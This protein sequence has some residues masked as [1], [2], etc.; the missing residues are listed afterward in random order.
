MNRSNAELAATDEPIRHG[1]IVGRHS[2]APALRFGRACGRARVLCAHVCGR[3]H[4]R[5][6][7]P[8]SLC[9]RRR[10]TVPG[11]RSVVALDQPVCPRNRDLVAEPVYT[12]LRRRP[13]PARP[14]THHAFAPSY[15]PAAITSAL[16]AND[17]ARQLRTL[18]RREDPVRR[19]D[20]MSVTVTRRC[21]VWRSSQCR[22]GAVPARSACS[23]EHSTCVLEGASVQP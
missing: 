11:S 13:F 10:R 2:R 9:V 21:A 12:R 17:V 4:G 7:A 20:R 23:P 16:H 18:D 5:R 8:Q 19:H 15:L 14:S 3:C 22:G 6:L 1:A